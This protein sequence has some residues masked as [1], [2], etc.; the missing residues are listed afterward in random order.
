MKIFCITEVTSLECFILTCWIF[1]DVVIVSHHSH[2]SSCTQLQETSN[3]SLRANLAHQQIV[4]SP[5]QFTARCLQEQVGLCAWAVSSVT[6][7][8]L[9][10]GGSSLPT[11]FLRSVPVKLWPQVQEGCMT[12]IWA[13]W[14]ED[15]DFDTAGNFAP[16]AGQHTHP[17]PSCSCPPSLFLELP[18]CQQHS[19]GTRAA[20]CQCSWVSITPMRRDPRQPARPAGSS[21]NTGV[22][23]GKALSTEKHFLY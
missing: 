15:G 3:Y 20:L 22:L 13:A 18:L 8:S 2:P 14:P 1:F 6:F 23:F 4:C 10:Q 16:S 7:M 21:A 11:R 19:A 17:L 12:Q 5:P 9:H